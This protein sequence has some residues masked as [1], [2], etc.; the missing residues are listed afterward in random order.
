MSIKFEVKHLALDL[1]APALPYAAIIIKK[2]SEKLLIVSDLHIGWE[3]SL[4]GQGIHIP[5]QTPKIVEKIVELIEVYKPTGLIL[6][7]DVKHT[8][9][10]IELSEWQDVPELFEKISKYVSDIRV[11]L[12]NHDGN[13]EALTPRNIKILDAKGTILLEEVGV[14]HGHAWPSFD[15]LKCRYLIMG[16]L[17][18][19]ITLRD[20]FGFRTTRQ[21]WVKTQCDV[22]KLAVSSSKQRARTKARK[23]FI[24]YSSDYSRSSKFIIMPSFNELLGGQPVNSTE[25]SNDEN[26]YFGPVLRSKSVEMD[27]AEVYLLDGTFLGKISN[28]KY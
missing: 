1:L 11:V 14:F 2:D 16:H 9:T 13:L 10:G 23:D 15:L 8:V 19:V 17:H 12:G 22:K 7:G 28:L 6:L 18:P 24:S 4:A 21:V 27:E 26:F 25:R 5:S 3:V 20:G